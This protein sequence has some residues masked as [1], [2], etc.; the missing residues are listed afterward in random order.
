[1]KNIGYRT[2]GKNER[3]LPGDE[4]KGIYD[5]PPCWKI[6]DIKI[7]EELYPRQCEYLT[8]RRAIKK[9]KIG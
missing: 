3:V 7:Y 4:Y 5:D 6:S 2:L 8:F 9:K 1:M